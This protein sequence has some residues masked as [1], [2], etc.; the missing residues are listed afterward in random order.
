MSYRIIKGTVVIDGKSPDGDTVSF[1]IGNQ[2]DWVW[3]KTQDG[4]F[5]RLNERYQTSIR[6]E[7]IDALELHY[8]ISN[9][10]PGLNVHQ[11]LTH[12]R[13]ARD[14]L[15]E[16]LEFDMNGVIE[17]ED[18]SL[19]DPAKQEKAAILAYNGIDPYGRI[20]GFVFHED[21]GL[22]VDDK[23][24]TIQ[25]RPEHIDK[26]LNA[27]LLSEGL[28]Y[29]AFYGGLYPE[30]RDRL[31]VIASEAME[32]EIGIWGEH[33]CEFVFSRQPSISDIETKV[34]M[35]KLFRRLSEHLAKNGA[36]SNF[37]NALRE[38]NDLTV[39]LKEVRLTDFSSFVRTEKLGEDE[40]RLWLSHKPG[41]MVFLGG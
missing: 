15:L 10:Y 8:Q 40:Y 4:R 21:I 31:K 30:L 33:S 36:I 13:R 12:A 26:S 29:P 11:P 25:L 1:S 23:H 18:L 22:E 16:L 2:A 17:K 28:V 19:S 38:A 34:M 41:E 37:R 32:Q 39:D 9:V 27:I 24:P 20:I 14:R 6:F 5:P 7:A 3:P 35:P